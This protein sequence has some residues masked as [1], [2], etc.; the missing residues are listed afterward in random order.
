M[1]ESQTNNG[2]LYSDM[3]AVRERAEDAA[4][5]QPKNGNNITLDGQADVPVAPS[6]SAPGML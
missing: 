5:T 6:L 2:W 1:R 3:H 4:V